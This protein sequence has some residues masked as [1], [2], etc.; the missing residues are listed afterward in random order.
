MSRDPIIIKTP[1][2]IEIMRKAGAITAGARSVAR[3]AIAGGLTTRQVNREVNDFIIKSRAIPTFKGYGAPSSQAV[4]PE[5]RS[6]ATAASRQAPAS[7]LTKRSSTV[8]PESASFTT[9]I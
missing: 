2:E 5:R 6:R 9:A 4:L 3:A 1:H 7:P 8:S